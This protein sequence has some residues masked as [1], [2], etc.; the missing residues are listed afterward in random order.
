MAKV[1]DVAVQG[2]DVTWTSE[3]KITMAISKISA[4][5]R[6]GHESKA[7][8]IPSNQHVLIIP[9]SHYLNTLTWF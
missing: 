8:M 9:I 7:S 5:K 3:L 1:S 6:V 2:L 4:Q